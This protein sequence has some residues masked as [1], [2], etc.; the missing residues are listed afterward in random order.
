MK[1]YAQH[2]AY[3]EPPFIPMGE[4]GI[5]KGCPFL[6]FTLFVCDGTSKAN[7]PSQHITS[8]T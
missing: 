2:W 6:A 5:I 8:V 7:A 3:Q 1:E 4:A